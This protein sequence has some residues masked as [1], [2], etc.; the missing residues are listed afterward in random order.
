MYPNKITIAATEELPEII[1]DKDLGIF[2]IKGRSLSNEVGIFFQ[3][4]LDWFMAYIKTPNASTT[5]SCKIEYF[6]STS[7]KYLMELFRVMENTQSEKYAMHV[8]WH[9]DKDDED[10]EQIGQEYARLLKIP[11]TYIQD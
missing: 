8:N 4:V 2:E 10:L 11:F 1:F 9:F 7:Q 3:P 5:L 6:N